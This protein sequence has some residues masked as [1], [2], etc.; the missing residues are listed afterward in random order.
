MGAWGFQLY[1][2]GMTLDVQ[3]YYLDGLR[4]GKTGDE[5]TKELTEFFLQQTDRDDRPLFW[6]ALADTQWEYSRLDPFVKEEALLVLSSGGD[7]ARWKREAPKLTLCEGVFFW[8][9][10]QSS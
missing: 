6:L 4:L 7:M 2:D 3:Q 8:C 10:R 1:D 9:Y 5:L